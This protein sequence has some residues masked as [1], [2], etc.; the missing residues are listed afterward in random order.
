MKIQKKKVVKKTNEIV[1]DTIEP[2]KGEMMLE[3][4]VKKDLINQRI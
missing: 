1:I 2:T 4:F 3:D